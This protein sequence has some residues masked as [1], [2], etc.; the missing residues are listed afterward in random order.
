MRVLIADDDPQMRTWLLRALSGLGHY[1]EAVADAETLVLRAVSFEPDAILSDIGLPG[2][3]GIAAGLWVRRTRP[4]CRIVLM[5]GDLVRVED[6][7]RAGFSEVLDKPFTLERLTA[8]FSAA[9]P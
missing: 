3:D 7:R 9:G 4:R 2:L 5:S 1:T 8:A 6:A